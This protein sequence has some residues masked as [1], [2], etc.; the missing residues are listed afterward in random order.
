MWRPE[1][2][3]YYET[4]SAYPVYLYKKYL[5][6][7]IPVFIH[8]HEYMSKED[9]SQGMKLVRFFHKKE[10][11]L[12]QRVKW[13]SQTNPDRLEKFAENEN[14]VELEKL[15]VLPN[16]PPLWWHS[17]HELSDP[18]PLKFIYIG[19][20]SLETM[21]TKQ[22]A[23]WVMMQKG[24]AVWD[25]HSF[26]VT[27]AAKKYFEDINS[28]YINLKGPVDYL[29]L[30]SILRNYQVGVILYNGSIPNYIYNAPNKESILEHAKQGGFPANAVLT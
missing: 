23:D 19:A 22:F 18:I 28:P 3:L 25:I 14:L 15:F 7:N 2:I 12:Y 30:P 27:G 11:F 5:N 17:S 4:L 21:Y 29:Q 20:L 16:Y 26:N 8:Y 10:K 6:K 13:I 1:K 9:Y 24:K